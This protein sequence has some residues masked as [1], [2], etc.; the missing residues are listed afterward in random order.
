[1]GLILNFRLTHADAPRRLTAGWR[2]RML[3][4][5]VALLAVPGAAWAQDSLGG[6]LGS[7]VSTGVSSDAYGA[8]A[9]GYGG[10]LG[11]GVLPNAA[12]GSGLVNLRDLVE[13]PLM[14]QAP[15]EPYTLNASIGAFAGYTDNTALAGVGGGITGSRTSTFERVNPS[16]FATATSNRLQGN[17]AYTP[18]FYFYNNASSADRST[19]SLS[20]SGT[21]VLA[22]D[23]LFVRANAFATQASTSQLTTYNGLNSVMVNNESQVYT[24]SINPYL[25]HQFS[26]IASLN[27]GYIFSESYFDNSQ[28]NQ[29]LQTG[30][31]S[32]PS[33]NSASQTEFLTLSSGD[34]FQLFQHS[35][36]LRAA[37]YFANGLSGDGHR[38]SANYLLSYALNRFLTV[39]GE[40]GY[41]DL[42]YAATSVAG[43][44]TSKGYTYSGATGQGGIKYTPTE[45]SLISASYGYY[46]GG[47]SFSLNGH[48]HPT[49]RIALVATSTTGVTTNGQD[50]ANFGSVSSTGSDGVARLSAQ[51][52]QGTPLGYALGTSVT[53]PA[54]YRLT[55]SSLS[56]VYSLERD[57]FAANFSYSQQENIAAVATT[58][59][60]SS[61]YTLGSLSWQ[62][63]VS[64]DVNLSA[65]ANYGA[66]S[67]A[68]THTT[69]STSNPVLGGLVRLSDALT[70]TLSAEAD[71]VYA[72]Q[73]AY[74]GLN[75]GSK[76]ETM[77]VVY[78]G[79][80]QR[81]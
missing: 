32:T 26:D 79:L 29:N 75:Q 8:G 69:P 30:Q 57:T 42:S 81:F 21:A 71:Y 23:T 16:V 6:G 65:T 5:G 33:T 59:T 38:N 22:Q 24:A 47:G 74:A 15:Q 58:I 56:A 19:Q 1:M 34:D 37:Q 13:S 52:P 18:A 3:A 73:R 28:Q 44:A 61:V 43:V 10:G 9:G 7:S 31:K 45:L 66:Q 55:R 39:F 63:Q 12:L 70:Q 67:V 14:Q 80:T 2:A 50:L 35:V 11:G 76:L 68:A 27:T 77:N 51:G 46:D 36:Q 41:E 40:I 17:L 49:Q 72:H 4:G 62:H 25:V 20:A 60:A 54:P 64:E 48:L 53:N 78:F